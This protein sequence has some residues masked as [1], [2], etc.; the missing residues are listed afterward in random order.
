[1]EFLLTSSESNGQPV[2]Y[3][4][5]YRL[6]SRPVGGVIAA[7][8]N[9]MYN[10][11]ILPRRRGILWKSHR[12]SLS[13]RRQDRQLDHIPTTHCISWFQRVSMRTPSVYPS[14]RAPIVTR[15]IRG[16][17]GDDNEFRAWSTE[18]T[19]LDLQLYQIDRGR[20]GIKY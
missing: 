7:T 10:K 20:M 13:Y 15:T 1:M 8:R 18:R 5:A 14:Y 12:S 9:G 3:I 17:Y 11:L 2:K 4:I 19:F 6:A 16:V